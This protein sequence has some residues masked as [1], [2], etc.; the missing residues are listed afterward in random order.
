[1]TAAQTSFSPSFAH[2]IPPMCNAMDMGRTC[3]GRLM[4][5]CP[6]KATQQRIA[7]LDPQVRQ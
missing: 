2:A 6:T 1:M 5:R 7:P 4:R 3:T